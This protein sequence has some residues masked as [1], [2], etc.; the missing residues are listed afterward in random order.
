[1]KPLKSYTK[2]KIC[3]KFFTQHVIS[4]W[5]ALPNEVISANSIATFKL[6]LDSYWGQIGYMD[7]IKGL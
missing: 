1:M 6:K 3:S 2:L 4:K 7:M 5:N